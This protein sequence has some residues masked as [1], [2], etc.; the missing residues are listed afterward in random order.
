MKIYHTALIAIGRRCTS[1]SVQKFIMRLFELVQ[2]LVL[3]LVHE[4]LD[5]HCLHRRLDLLQLHASANA[6]HVGDTNLVIGH[7]HHGL[8]A[9]HTFGASL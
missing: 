3:S 8:S 6:L 5:S 1:S 9:H 4:T 7:T 2:I